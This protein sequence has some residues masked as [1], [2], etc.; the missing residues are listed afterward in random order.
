MNL[1]TTPQTNTTHFPD[2]NWP[3]MNDVQR[4]NFGAVASQ[5][6]TQE[7]IFTKISTT[8]ESILVIIVKR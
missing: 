1:D 6:H 2:D 7:P 3:I 8:V 4:E 5:K